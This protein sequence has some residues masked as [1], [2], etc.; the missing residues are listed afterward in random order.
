MEKSFFATKISSDIFETLLGTP[1]VSFGYTVELP[2]PQM[3]RSIGMPPS[4]DFFC[5]NYNLFYVFF[6]QIVCVFDFHQQEPEL[7]V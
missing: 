3:S 7:M 5:D 1:V 6:G 4:R 2:P